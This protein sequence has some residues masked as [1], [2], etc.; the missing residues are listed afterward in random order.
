MIVVD[1]NIIGY[2]YLSSPWSELAEKALLKDDDW[3]APRSFR[4]SD[5]PVSPAKVCLK[6]HS[7][8]GF[9]VAGSIHRPADSSA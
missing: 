7:W 2:L 1:T 5:F 3:A 4:G 8:G 6:P 9:E